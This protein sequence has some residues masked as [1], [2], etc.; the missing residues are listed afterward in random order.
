MQC[1]HF[2]RTPVFPKSKQNNFI[3]LIEKWTNVA[4]SIGYIFNLLLWL[5]ARRQ[6]TES[7]LPGLVIYHQLRDFWRPIGDKIFVQITSDFLVISD[8]GQNLGNF[9]PFVVEIGDF[10]IFFYDFNQ[11]F[12]IFFTNNL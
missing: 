10:S 2:A 9:K 12:W 8:V 1:P 3:L 7:V 6:G 11:R 5:K 4:A